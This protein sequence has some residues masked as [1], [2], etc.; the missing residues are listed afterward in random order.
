MEVHAHTHTP[1]KKWTHY[2]WEFLMLFLAVF[3]GFLA[4]NQREHMIEH[5]REKQFIRSM[6]EDV[7]S[8]TVL[9]SSAIG[10]TKEIRKVN[11]QFLEELLNSEVARNSYKA[12][13]LWIH[14]DYIANFLQNDRTIQQL[15][16]SGNM[17]LIRNKNV[18]DSIMEYDLQVRWLLEVQEKINHFI[19]QNKQYGF[20]LFSAGG[21]AKKVNTDS[22]GYL[23]WMGD[24]IFFRKP[25]PLLNADPAFINEVYGYR[26]QFSGYLYD[27]F[28]NQ[29]YV[30][31]R[32]KRLIDFIKK[33]YQLK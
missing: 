3:C 6:V 16:S 4:E 25:V 10:V 1:R 24:S 11:Y 12:F 9:L 28:L 33:E 15:K 31:Y 8:D 17:R 21:F 7:K 14:S 29:Q 19:L 22:V 20:R 13:Y 23:L 26:M 30:Y 5:R 32:G 18:S 2:F 27:L